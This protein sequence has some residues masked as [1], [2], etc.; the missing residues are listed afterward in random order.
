M[1]KIEGLTSHQVT[2]IVI[3]FILC[4]SLLS[5][6]GCYKVSKYN[7]E[8]NSIELKKIELEIKKLEK[9]PDKKIDRQE[10]L[11]EFKKSFKE[12]DEIYSS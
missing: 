4:F 8:I 11:E 1:E 5:G 7:K 3:T 10:L 6:Y 12:H 9:P 2:A